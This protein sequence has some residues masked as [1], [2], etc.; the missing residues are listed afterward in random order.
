MIFFCITQHQAY[1]L[2]ALTQVQITFHDMCTCVSANNVSSYSHFIII[3]CF[4]RCWQNAAKYNHEVGL[5][6]CNA[7]KYHSLYYCSNKKF[8]QSK[9]KIVLDTPR[10]H[11][12]NTVV[13]TKAVKPTATAVVTVIPQYNVCVT[14]TSRGL[15]TVAQCLRCGYLHYGHVPFVPFECPESQVWPKYRPGQA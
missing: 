4:I 11:I 10:A 5:M 6:L 13:H 12:R 8:T 1:M 2:L 14:H 15:F 9:F 3:T 7:E